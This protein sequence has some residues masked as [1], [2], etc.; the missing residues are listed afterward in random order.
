MADCPV[1]ETELEATTFLK[2]DVAGCGMCGGVWIPEGGLQTMIKQA[3]T[4]LHRLEDQFQ[5]LR[6]AKEPP[7]RKLPCPGCGGTMRR[8]AAKQIPRFEPHVCSDCKG[9][10]VAEGGLKTVDTYFTAMKLK[11]GE[12]KEEKEVPPPTAAR[13][14]PGEPA[15][16]L[17]APTLTCSR[18]GN[19]NRADE[20]LCLKCDQPLVVPRREGHLE[21]QCPRCHKALYSAPRGETKVRACSECDGMWIPYRQL[22]QL[23]QN[24]AEQL[25]RLDTDFRLRPHTPGEEREIC[26]CPDC[27]ADLQNVEYAVELPDGRMMPAGEVVHEC[28]RCRGV[29]FDAGESHQLSLKAQ[30]VLAK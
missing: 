11:K 6:L 9:L 20:R 13:V 7:P 17:K 1:C 24:N 4:L 12:E 21:N 18:C 3:P 29:W 26:R 10:W 28:P 8:T 25:G 16:L 19:V 2:V 30:K 5:D 14:E 15:K 23:L 22:R 27:G